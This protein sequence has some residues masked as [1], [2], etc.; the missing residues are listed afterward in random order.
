MRWCFRSLLHPLWLAVVLVSEFEDDVVILDEDPSDCVVVLVTDDDV[1]VEDV[2][3]VDDRR[4]CPQASAL[5]L[6]EEILEPLVE[7]GDPQ[8]RVDLVDLGWCRGHGFSIPSV[9]SG[10]KSFVECS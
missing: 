3:R 4:Y 2:E 10:V 6:S 7:V 1:G 8:H 5:E 9:C